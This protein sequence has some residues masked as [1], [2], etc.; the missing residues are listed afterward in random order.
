MSAART[1]RAAAASPSGDCA[2]AGRVRRR[3]IDAG[4]ER[5]GRRAG[6]GA[7]AARALPGVRDVVPA[8]RARS[9]S[10]SIRCGSTSR[11][12]SGPSPHA[13]DAGP[14]ASAE[15]G[16]LVEIPVCYGGELRARPRRG[17]GVRRAAAPTTSSR[18]TR[19]DRTASTCSASCP[20]FAY[21]GAVDATIADAAP[22][23]R[24]ARACR[25]AAS[26]SPGGRPASIRATARA[27]GSSSAARRGACSTRRA[28]EPSLL[29]AGDR[30]RFVP[31]A[32][33]QWPLSTAGRRRDA[34]RAARG[35]RPGLLTTVQDLGRWGHQARGRAGGGPD[36]HVRASPRQ[37]AR[38]QRRRRRRRSRSR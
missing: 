6:R 26:A 4:G 29:D 33:G 35:A 15:A 25:R 12:S 27:A 14:A 16:P 9:A 34:A 13:W 1:S 3:A 10:T 19:R 17:R 11:R 32:A 7:R 22:R 18:G 21:L 5:A 38:R 2:A 23:R 37:R 24:R 30:V 28:R 36:G 8:Y 20:G 31:V